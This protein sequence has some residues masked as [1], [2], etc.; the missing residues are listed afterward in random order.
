[1]ARKRA[2][3]Q[4]DNPIRVP[5]DYMMAHDWIGRIGGVLKRVLQSAGMKLVSD[6]GLFGCQHRLGGFDIPATCQLD[7]DKRECDLPVAPDWCP[8][9]AECAECGHS[10][11]EHCGCG[12]HC[13]AP[14][15][16]E[17]WRKPDDGKSCKCSGWK[18]KIR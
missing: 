16:N 5:I 13:L 12:T 4:R 1:M 10:R 9:N 2:K 15:H 7:P 8:L 18:P 6:G 17:E 3:R 11:T 14:L